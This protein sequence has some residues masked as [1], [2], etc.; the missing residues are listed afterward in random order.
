MSDIERDEHLRAALRHA[1]DAALA[2]PP[3][4][5]AQILAAAHRATAEHAPAAPPPPRRWWVLQTPWRLGASGGFATLLLAG[6]VALL[7]QGE[8]PGPATEAAYEVAANAPAPAPTPAP[9]PQPPPAATAAA[10]VADAAKPSAPAKAQRKQEPDQRRDAMALRQ[11]A[12]EERDLARDNTGREAQAQLK[13]ERLHAESRVAAPATNAAAP[14]AAAPPPPAAPAVPAPAPA[15][16]VLGRAAPALMA[17]PRP[18]GPWMDALAAGSAVQWTVDGQARAPTSSWLYALAEQ[19]QGRWRPAANTQPVAGHN[20]VTWQR[21]DTLL[22]RLWL[23]D[24][25]VLWCDAQGRC[26]ETALAAEVGSV[27]R[28]G[29]AR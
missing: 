7:W 22:G 17:A 11:R 15:T 13:E 29:L 24:E 10:T 21:G 1:P 16:A 26:E 3:E 27:L 5:S 23:G 18:S 14:A 20:T 12:Q 2:A 19:T 28:K 4:L 8:T 6:V 9:A 25:H